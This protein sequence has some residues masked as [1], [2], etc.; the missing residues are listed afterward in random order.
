MREPHPEP[1][2]DS[3]PWS[4]TTKAIVA[5]LALVLGGILVYYFRGLIQPLVVAC[6]LAYILNPLV[7]F[8]SV[9]TALTRRT[10]VL[11]VYGLLALAVLFTLSFI[12]FTTFQQ[13]AILS[14]NLPRWF[15][16]AVELLQSL[17]E[18]LPSA[19]AIGPY[20]LP[21]NL[22]LPQLPGWNDVAA[23]LF[24]W[25]EPIFSRGGSVA[26]QVIGTTV[27]A[28]ALVLLVFVV[29]IY[30]AM[31]M[32]KIGAAISDVAQQPGYRR[33]AERLMAEISRVWGAYL[34]G[35]VVLGL[36]IF[37]VVSVVLG[38]LGVSNA[39]G[40]GLL[41]GA[42]E[43]L[44]VIGPLIGSGAAILVAFF[45][46]DNFWGLSQMNYALVVTVAMIL[47]QQLE[48]NI[49]APRI[50]GEALDLHPLLV[51][52]SVIM[53][54][55]L[56]GLLGAILAAPVVASLKLLG[57]YAWRKMLDL[58]PFPDEPSG[59]P[60]PP[61]VSWLARGRALWGRL[62]RG[63]VP[64]SSSL[65]AQE[66][67]QTGATAKLGQRSPTEK[68]VKRG[69]VKE[70]EEVHMDDELIYPLTFAPVF[71]D[72]PWG[73]RNLETKLG[74]EI[75]EG[76]VAESW[77]ISGHPN[78]QTPVRTGPLAGLTLSD[79]QAKLG[80]ALLGSRN[81]R[82]LQLDK[83]PVLIK[84]LDAHRWLSVQVHPN[85][86]YAL[87][88][89]GELGKTEMW[90]VLHAEPGAELIYG[91]K[92]G[93]DRQTF[94]AA[95]AEERSQDLLHRLT[96]E[97]GDV[98]FVPA[99]SVHALGPGIVVAEIQQNSDTTYRIYDW[100]RLGNDGKPRPLHVDQ[101]LAVIDWEQ[102]EPGPVTPVVLADN[103]VR[104][105]AIGGC[106]YFQ[107]ERLHMQ[108]GSAYTDSCRGQT[109]QI[110]G[111]LRGQAILH[112]QGEPVT[113]SAVSW[114]L[115]PAAL[116]EFSVRSDEES[117]LLRVFT[118]EPDVD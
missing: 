116:G 85:D 106:P 20:S 75:P 81:R 67:E 40:L 23:Q 91:L 2:Y 43:F 64:L 105:E 59:T 111:I 25:I 38:I 69:Q 21:L 22:E 101:A 93:V 65:P 109:F 30:I 113:L 72:Y 103:G 35:Q 10:V 117:V 1:Q 100:G 60:S 66:A 19:L 110:W 32:P 3:P 63:R 86:E 17:P 54:A 87:E 45:Q 89:E 31:D 55:T 61:A 48:N 27:N 112:W 49:L 36:V 71:K 50:V 98:I 53:G 58:P 76:I 28:F 51:M 90:V 42:M 11:I 74:R 107:S 16:R 7:T 82:A 52:V 114:V 88:H 68:D 96:V 34:R 15:A 97:A 104:L 41:S 24:A 79:V 99:G 77:E 92:S 13:A 9:R 94:I 8:L 56:A 84:L 62:R 5:V 4:T 39:L 70:K 57:A 12:G 118:P 46:P 37:T 6:L 78:G 83:F 95:V 14:Q 44:P 29:S 26:T 102:V 33:D 73:G 47:I 80:E 18:R 115:L 108:S